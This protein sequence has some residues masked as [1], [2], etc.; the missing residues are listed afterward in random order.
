MG[1]KYFWKLSPK[2]V[3]SVS[4][5]VLEVYHKLIHNLPAHNI[6]RVRVYAHTRSLIRAVA[7]RQG[8]KYKKAVRLYSKIRGDCKYE[9][10]HP[11]GYLK[12]DTH[13]F[14]AYNINGVSTYPYVCLSGENINHRSK[15]AI[16]FLMLHEFAHLL[17]WFRTGDRDQYLSESLADKW[18]FAIANQLYPVYRRK[19]LKIGSR[20][21]KLL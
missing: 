18:A 11:N 16:A 13:R 6:F 7:K 3:G 14:S 17:H 10:Y 15:W 19:K 20:K 1:K 8:I 5:K 9:R 4:P 21:V 2:I 12:V